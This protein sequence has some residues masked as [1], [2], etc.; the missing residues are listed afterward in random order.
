MDAIWQAISPGTP[1]PEDYSDVEFWVDPE[2]VGFLL[3]QGEYIKTWRRRWFVLKKGKLLWFRD[4]ADVKP[5]AVPRGIV[6]VG[7]C[8]VI[9]GAEDVINKVNSFMVHI[10]GW[11][12]YFVA[13]TDKEKEEW[14]NSIA[15]AIVQ[16]SGAVAPDILDYNYINRH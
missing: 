10:D 16:N 1:C 14:I 15:R 3:K 9:R 12:T 5:T 8:T 4:P 7:K 2:R 13:D 11:P 6:H